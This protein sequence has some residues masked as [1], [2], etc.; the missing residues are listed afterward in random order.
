MVAHFSEAAVCL[1]LAGLIKNLPNSA[2]SNDLFFP[3]ALI[4]I[5]WPQTFVP[6]AQ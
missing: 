3:K 1:G 6:V 2:T 5:V 4:L